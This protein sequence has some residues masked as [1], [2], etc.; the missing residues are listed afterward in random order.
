MLE[1]IVIST[2]NGVLF[3]MLLFLLSSGLTVIFS[4]MGVLNFAHASFYMLG[5]FFG[6]Q[7]TKWIGFWP[8]L[9]LAPLLYLAADARDWTLIL[10]SIGIVMGAFGQVTVND[11]M[12]GKYTAEEWRS[13]AYAVRYFVGFTAA[14][15]SVGLVAWLYERGGFVTMLQAFAALA[16]VAIVAALILPPELPAAQPA[17]RVSPAE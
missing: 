1:L 5:A 8:A 10:S 9:V 12:V 16:L 4:M 17:L 7:L 13:R 2:L 14:G 11:A 6:F 15:A 3:G